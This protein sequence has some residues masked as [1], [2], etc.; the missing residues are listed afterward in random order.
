ML[1]L[2]CQNFR[3]AQN[4][5]AVSEPAFHADGDT[6]SADDLVFSEIQPDTAED[7]THRNPKA[8]RDRIIRAYTRAGT[9]R[10]AAK[11]LDV[12]EKT[13]IQLRKKHHINR[14]GEIEA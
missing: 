4:T 9:W 1:F 6:I 10:G 11:L 12:S 8:E 14:D 5:E 2:I 13:L 3:T 7:L